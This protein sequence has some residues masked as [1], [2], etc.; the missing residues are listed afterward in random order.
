MC[1]FT[2]VSDSDIPPIVD[3]KRWQSKND[4]PQAGIS[5][6]SGINGAISIAV[7]AI[8]YRILI[9]GGIYPDFTGRS[10]NPTEYL[11][12]VYLDIPGVKCTQC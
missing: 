5:Y 3:D 2:N 6:R 8:Y 12:T 7:A 1:R 10:C 11:A 4:R 9:S